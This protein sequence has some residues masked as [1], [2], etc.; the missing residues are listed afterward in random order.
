[1]RY[2]RPLLKVP[3]S[4]V[5]ADAPALPQWAHVQPGG[6]LARD[7]AVSR[8]AAAA[9]LAL[10]ASPGS[11][12][13]AIGV[14]VALLILAA[15]ALAVAIWWTRRPRRAVTRD[16]PVAVADL[17]S[18]DSRVAARVAPAAAGEAW[19]RSLP[20]QPP[21][22]TAAPFSAAPPAV[23][24]PSSARP[25][26]TTHEVTQTPDDVDERSPEELA[27]AALEQD[28][29]GAASTS[30][31]PPQGTADSK[32][33]GRDPSADL[34]QAPDAG[35]P[36]S[37]APGRS[38]GQSDLDTARPRP[39]AARLRLLGLALGMLTERT[40]R[41]QP[42][43]LG[44]ALAR[45]V[46]DDQE[47]ARRQVS[48]L[49]L[50]L[51]G[52]DQQSGAGERQLSLFLDDALDTELSQGFSFSAMPEFQQALNAVSPALREKLET[53]IW[54]R[55]AD[56]VNL[57]TMEDVETL[58]RVAVAMATALILDTS[59]GGPRRSD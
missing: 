5:A 50:S 27:A 32:L 37:L 16:V 8:T 1:M 6:L 29:S 30:E 46:D 45:L 54:T 38:T 56:S 2:V 19:D 13:L 41:E 9:P 22:A 10:V 55:N 42:P 26:H 49:A 24:A 40:G 21:P 11:V 4:P 52:E 12:G 18:G 28:P 57:L 17:R 36:G 35:A 58:E 47:A 34:E 51:L 23:A 44:T 3:A 53:I 25:E 7:R 15:I 43:Q 20:H 59:Y 31:V 39:E 14:V 48:T 33:S